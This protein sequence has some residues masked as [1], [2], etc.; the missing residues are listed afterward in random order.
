MTETAHPPSHPAPRWYDAPALRALF[1]AV[2]FLTRL[3]VPGGATRDLTTFAAD[4]KRGL[5]YFP[6]IGAVIGAIAAAALYLFALALPFPVAVLLA[7]AVE[8]IVTGAFH[9]DGVAD[10]FDAFGAARTRDDTLRILKDSRIGSYGV[11]GLGLMVATRAAALIALASPL[12]AGVVLVV[13]GAVGRL[14]SLVMMALVPPASNRDTLGREGLGETVGNTA[15]WGKVIAAA[16]LASPVLALGA[17]RDGTGLALSLA[18]LAMFALWF[19]HLLLRRLGGSTGDCL[20]F[21]AYAGIVL[22]TIV[23]SRTS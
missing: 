16:F 13:S 21:A 10:F 1:T 7:L 9:E 23:F 4:I 11:M 6:L 5:K 20:G 22:T 19:R 2:Q 17:W 3:P 14:L 12:A 15:D 18:L 8:A